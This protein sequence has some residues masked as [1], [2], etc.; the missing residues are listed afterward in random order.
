MRRD[1][2]ILPRSSR[3][4]K[5][6]RAGG[7]VPAHTVAPASAS[8]LA[9]AKPYPP[10][11]ATP[12]TN[13]RLPRR[14][15]LNIHPFPPE[16]GMWNAEC[17]MSARVSFAERPPL[18]IPHSAFRIPHCFFPPASNEKPRRHRNQLRVPHECMREDPTQRPLLRRDRVR[19]A[20]EGVEKLV[21][22]ILERPLEPIVLEV[23]V[24]EELHP[25]GVI[26]RQPA[27]TGV[28]GPDEIGRASCRESV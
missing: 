5:M 9:M 10:S 6:F 26:R 7:Q 23:I 8:A 15:M 1:S 11:S 20:R 3:F 21:I 14:S 16:C 19:G 2:S 12:A 13:A 22:Q 18:E 17:G 4:R 25:L 24:S 27:R 28:P